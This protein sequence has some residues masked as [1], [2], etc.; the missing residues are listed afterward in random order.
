MGPRAGIALYER[1][2]CGTPAAADQDHLSVILMAFP[3]K[4]VDRTLFLEGIVPVNPAYEIARVIDR[5][6]ASGAEVIGMACNTSHSPRI[7]DVILSEIDRFPR[8]LNLLH[9]PREVGNYF[10]DEYPGIRRIG[11]MATNGTYR[12]GLYNDILEERGYE[13][14]IP[15]RDFQ[16]DVIHRMIYDP[17]I[18][19]KANANCI[20]E[21]ASILFNEAL[22]YFKRRKAEAI[23]LGCTELSLVGEKMEGM[24]L[25]DSTACLARALIR[26]GAGKDKVL[27]PLTHHRS[28]I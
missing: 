10:N 1:I 11:V 17:H 3:K 19:I 14:V 15:D 26:E 25:V 16:N 20:T 6:A 23:V 7:F 24:L 22:T 28:N 18:G 2:T 5:L 21:E 27:Q 8:K 12:S 13:V 4:I 9:M